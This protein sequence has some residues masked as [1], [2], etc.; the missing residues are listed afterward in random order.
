MRDIVTGQS[1][2]ALPTGLSAYRVLVS[3][4]AKDGFCC[5]CPL[6]IDRSEVANLSELKA[7]MDV[8]DP[9]TT[10]IVG[11]DKRIL[12]GPCRNGEMLTIV[13]LVPDG[14]LSTARKGKLADWSAGDMHE[15]SSQTS[16]TSEGSLDEVLKSYHDFPEWTKEIFRRAPGIGLWQLRDIEPLP[17]WVKG[18]TI[19]IGDAAHAMLPLQG[20]G[21]SQ[22]FEDAEALQAIFAD[23]HSQPSSEDVRNR[24]KKVFKG[25]YERASLVQ[26]YSRAQAPNQKDTGKN[27][28][29]KLNP[30]EFYNYNV[31]YHGFDDWVT[32]NPVV[33]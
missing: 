6:Q 15:D 31:D 21:A 22:T 1:I 29:V 28:E 26:K 14:E 16:W 30:M 24:L 17:T 19:L 18:K 33:A 8:E 27:G 2:S 20:Q 23:V 10:M 4:S 7:V 13:A 12:M 25:R 3:S 5:R 32:K 9:Y 11:K